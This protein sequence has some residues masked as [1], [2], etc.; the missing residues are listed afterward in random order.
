MSLLSGAN[1]GEHGSPPASLPISRSNA[2]EGLSSRLHLLAT[3]RR[4]S[5]H[6][7]ASAA[8][9]ARCAQCRSSS[10]LPGARSNYIRELFQYQDRARR[11]CSPSSVPA[12]LGGRTT[13]HLFSRS[14]VH[15]RLKPLV[16][17]YHCSAY[18][19][20]NCQCTEC[21]KMPIGHL[22]DLMS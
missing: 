3:S 1:G 19:H 16:L 11:P 10:A 9:E 8:D 15:P 2:P 5:L 20:R 14:L 13:V 12:A 6:P 4:I 17:S 18:N 21:G 22:V 7:G